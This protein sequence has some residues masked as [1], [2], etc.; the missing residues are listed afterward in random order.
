MTL[1]KEAKHITLLKQKRVDGF[2]IA[3]VFKKNEPVLRQLIEEEIPLVLISLH[4]S[5]LPVGS[6]AGDDYLGGYIATEHLLSLGHCRI[7]I[8]AQ[9]ET[10][11]GTERVRGYEKGFNKCRNRARQKNLI[12]TTTDLTIE[13]AQLCARELLASGQRPTAIFLAVMIH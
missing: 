8:I 10:V 9:E 7:G 11:S 1:K 13:G 12:R 3:S 6:V 2:I 4:R 5:E